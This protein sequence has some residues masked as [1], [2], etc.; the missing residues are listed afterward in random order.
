L[1]WRSSRCARRAGV[2]NGVEEVPAPAEEQ[3]RFVDRTD[4]SAS[5]QDEQCAGLALHYLFGAI[6]L[7]S[8]K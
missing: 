8:S 1:G 4:A 2:G 6:P 5:G 3:K 7:S